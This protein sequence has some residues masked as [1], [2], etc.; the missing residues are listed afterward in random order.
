MREFR[1]RIAAQSAEPIRWVDQKQLPTLTGTSPVSLFRVPFTIVCHLVCL[2]IS[3]QLIAPVSCVR[4]NGN[5]PFSYVKS[6]VYECCLA[7][8]TTTTPLDCIFLE[9]PSTCI[10]L[11][12]DSYGNSWRHG[13]PC[14]AGVG[15]GSIHGP[16]DCPI[17]R[18]SGST[19]RKQL[20]KSRR[21]SCPYIPCK[22]EPPLAD[23]Y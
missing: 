1:E 19:W 10:I 21:V 5:F 8:V 7:A 9:R 3:A 22:E 20:D 16:C 2:V 13:H 12:P 4:S 17:K 15:T 23:G 18:T 6:G 14:V 11:E